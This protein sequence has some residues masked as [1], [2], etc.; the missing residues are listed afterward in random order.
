LSTKEENT[1]RFAEGLITQ[2]LEGKKRSKVMERYNRS[3]KYRNGDHD[4]KKNSKAKGNKVFNKYAEIFENRVAHFVAKRPKWKYNPQ[5]ED[6]LISADIANQV[7]GDV[8]WELD[9][10]EDKGEDSL[11]EA[12]DAGSSHIKT[13]LKPGYSGLPTYQVVPASALAPDPHTKNKRQLRWLIH[14]IDKGVKD[15]RREYG[16]G[17]VPEM[18]LEKF[19]E[20]GSFERPEI[21]W[22]AT[23][24]DTMPNIWGGTN[25]GAVF[26]EV[27]KKACPIISGKLKLLKSGL[28]INQKNQYLL[29]Q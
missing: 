19:E 3:I 23:G 13:N 14:F 26:D 12:A 24:D 10:W 9:E 22:E 17:V 1:I 11:Y 29:S 8:L 21:S 4:I 20:I 6:D 28:K 15:I 7:I 5:S 18:Y 27:K 16:V 2:S 25:Y